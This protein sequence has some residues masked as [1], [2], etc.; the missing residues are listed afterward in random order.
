MGIEFVTDESGNI[1]TYDV[2]TNTNY[3][4]TAEK[5]AYNR[6]NY[7]MREIALFLEKERQTLINNN[8]NNVNNNSNNS[9][10]NTTID[11]SNNNSIL[12]A[13][14]STND[15]HTTVYGECMGMTEWGSWEVWR[16]WV[17]MACAYLVTRVHTAFK[18]R[19]KLV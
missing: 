16:G 13:G 14:V 19:T 17:G 15:K 8:T 18:E 9:N 3:N 4:S 1:W 10:S 5:H 6:P 7:C 12:P 11:N 2:N